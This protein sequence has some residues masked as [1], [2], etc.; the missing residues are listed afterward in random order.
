MK[1]IRLLII[2]L[3]LFP[4]TL[5]ISQISHGG[6][7]H[8][9]QPSILKVS[10]DPFFIEMPSFNLDSILREDAVNAEKMRTSYQFAHKFYTHIDS[11]DASQTIL[12]DGTTVK[13]IGIRSAG[14][15]S[16]N[17]LFRDF[18]IPL[19][20]KL[21]I[22]S[23]DHSHVIGSFDHRNNSS[24]K[25]LP[26]QP[27]AG[28]SIIVEYSEP[29]NVPFAGHFKIAEVNHGYRDVFRAEPSIDNDVAYACMPDVFCEDVAEETIR[30]TVLLIINGNTLCSGALINNTSDDG[31]PYVLT[32]NHCLCSPSDPPKD[33]VN[34]YNDRAAT[35]IAFFNYNT[36]VCHDTI[37]MKGAE[38]MSLAGA[39]PRVILE[40]KDIALLEFY[41][42]PP[43]YFNVYYAGWKSNLN[44]IGGRHTNIHHP[45]GAVKKYGVTEEKIS[46]ASVPGQDGNYLDPDSYWEIPSWTKGST[47]NGSSG[48]PLFDEN[49]LIIGGLTGGTSLCSGTS[50][51]GG[52][53]WFSILGK[54]WEN[55]DPDNQLKTYL[56]PKNTNRMKYTGLDPHEANPV[57]RLSNAQYTNGDLLL[58]SELSSPNKGFVFGNSNL[59][60]L[61]FA[62]EFSVSN[63]VEIFGT[64]LMMPAM[65]FNNTAGVTVSVYTGNSAPETK[66]YY[67]QFIPRYMNYSASS[68]FHQADKNTNIAPTETFVVFDKPVVVTNK[69]YI[70][71]A[72]NYSTTN[73][74]CVYNTK[75]QN[76]NTASK[77]WLKHASKGWVKADVYE[78]N[79]MK[80]SLAI[81][82]VVRNTDSIYVDPDPDKDKEIGFYFDRLERVLTLK[83][84][85]DGQG[86][87]AIYSISGQLLEKIRIQLDQTSFVLGERPKGTVCIVKIT[88]DYFSF[89]EK[90]MF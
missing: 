8:F 4:A 50:P 49:R 12:P 52:M 30:S 15:Y 58:M 67:T 3:L 5:A 71:Y 1:S 77:A 9:L 53:D 47:W 64:Y 21:F 44:E 86:E 10:S 78:Y 81:H 72:I 46:I 63:T 69:F 75:F 79:P 35:V 2:Q 51:N 39:F 31:R 62:E 22:Y 90:I 20:A 60:T 48:S 83:D 54:S 66:V 18:E 41:D 26:T 34:Y 89:T 80:T 70:S 17:L 88:S 25:I 27:V 76:A 24:D 73:Q 16:I 33:S 68:D 23:A 82:P 57:I 32:A 85:L 14:A 13:Q 37:K 45:N 29:L 36:P 28:E 19:G 59:Q 56:D 7:P 65:P 87:I 74:F 55:D 84:V 11:R 38:E 6:V 43:D 40:K 42:I 61:E